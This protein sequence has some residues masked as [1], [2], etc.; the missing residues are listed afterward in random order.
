MQA[1]TTCGKRLKPRGNDTPATGLCRGCYIDHA[2]VHGVPKPNCKV[3]GK[4]LAA[5]SATGLCREH[6][7]A[8]KTAFTRRCQCGSKLSTSNRS[9]KCEPCRRVQF[10]CTRC[11]KATKG[12]N[13]RKSGLCF[14]CLHPRREISVSAGPIGRIIQA[15]AKITQRS[16]AEI[17]GD[18]R[19]KSLVN[20]RYA[21]AYVAWCRVRSACRVGRAMRRDHSTI[22]YAVQRV[23]ALQ[24][25]DKHFAGLVRAIEAAA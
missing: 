10:T 17:V 14:T 15:A 19:E 21:T 8:E 3:C 12:G 24:L 22:L 20:T 11:G 5:K 13:R 4:R 16:Y 25:R 7:L 6:Y 18:G 23:E 9:G 1:C 2:R